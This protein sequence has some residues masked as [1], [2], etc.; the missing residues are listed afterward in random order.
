MVSLK[1]LFPLFV[2]I[3]RD[4]G[5]SIREAPQELFGESI[6]VGN[7]AFLVDFLTMDAIINMNIDL[8]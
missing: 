6:Y 3:R 5:K 2:H 8:H 1:D 4:G 7:G